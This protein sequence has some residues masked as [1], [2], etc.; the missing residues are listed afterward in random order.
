M[1]SIGYLISP[2]LCQ[3]LDIKILQPKDV[4]F[5]N[6]VVENAVRQ[7]KELNKRG[8]DFVQQLIDLTEIEGDIQEDENEDQDSK[9]NHKVN[10]KEGDNTLYYFLKCWNKILLL[11]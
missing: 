2:K 6:D 3:F 8:E 5:V 7:R 4:E 11:S 9:L 1:R 10:T